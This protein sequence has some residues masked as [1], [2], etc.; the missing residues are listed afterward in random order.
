MVERKP[1]VIAEAA[2][3]HYGDIDRAFAMV[4]AA[5]E[6][7]ADVIKF[8]HHIP[9]EE[10][11][12]DVPM[13]GNMAEPL[14]DF[15]VRNALSI[16]QHVL[17][18]AHCDSV[19]IRYL[20]TPFSLAAARELEEF[21]NP[22]WYKIGSGELTDLPTLLEIRSWGHPMIISTGMANV[23]EITDTYVA[24]SDEDAPLT[25]M[26]CTSAYPPSYS[27]VRLGF[28]EEM[29]TLYP[30]ADIGHSDHTPT[31][32]TA[33]AALAL[34][35]VMVEKHVTIDRDLQG[36]DQSVS[37]TFDDLTRLVD[38]RDRLWEARGATKEVLASE[39]EIREWARRSLVYLDNFPSGHI[40]NEGDIWGKRPGTG[41]PS[42]RLQEFIGRRL[43]REVNRNTLLQESDLD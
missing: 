35:C 31:I 37:I 30:L 7:G 36:P 40:L 18:K 3:A 17:L 28:I 33:V 11:L 27:D 10:M 21:V 2:D 29:R 1:Q 15:L 19:G 9:D 34:G 26:N 12:R 43:K 4:D 39:Q 16:Q 22:G 23:E 6:A 41:V 25:L 5:R 20:C 42:A 8:Q 24:L 14:Y 38:A 32:D 13:S